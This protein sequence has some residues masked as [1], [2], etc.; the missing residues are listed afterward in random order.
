MQIAKH[1]GMFQ[2]PMALNFVQ[3]KEDNERKGGSR[4]HKCRNE[5]INKEA[6][7]KLAANK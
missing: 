2:F 6:L 3:R 4:K 7:T 1:T 5:E